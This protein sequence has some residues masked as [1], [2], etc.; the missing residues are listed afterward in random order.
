MQPSSCWLGITHFSFSHYCSHLFTEHAWSF[1]SSE[2]RPR[3]WTQQPTF[4]RFA[5][6]SYMVCIACKE[7]KNTWALQNSF[8]R[9]Q[10][11]H[12]DLPVNRDKRLVGHFALRVRYLKDLPLRRG[13]CSISVLL[14]VETALSSSRFNDQVYSWGNAFVRPCIN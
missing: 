1:I 10:N 3:N 8:V 2:Y 12:L 13:M 11:Q 7:M 14:Y 6:F 5:P 4:R 9:V